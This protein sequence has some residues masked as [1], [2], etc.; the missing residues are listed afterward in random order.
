MYKTYEELNYQTFFTEPSPEVKKMLE[1]SENPYGAA[2][3]KMLEQ[4]K[5]PYGAATDAPVLVLEVPRKVSHFDTYV[6]V[7]RG[8]LR[9]EL[10][11]ELSELWIIVNL[12]RAQYHSDGSDASRDAWLRAC[13]KRAA[14]EFEMAVRDARIVK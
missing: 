8:L 4:S 12:R 9:G 14:F 10:L 7:A 1:M 2:G 3:E 5:N 13:A 6:A 11:D